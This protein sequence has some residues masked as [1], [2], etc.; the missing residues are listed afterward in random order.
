MEELA[1]ILTPEQL[2]LLPENLSKIKLVRAYP[3]GQV[4]LF[5]SFGVV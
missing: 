1:K 5:S 2:L 4:H 3:G